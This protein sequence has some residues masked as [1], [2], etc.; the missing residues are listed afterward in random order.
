MTAAGEG[1]SDSDGSVLRFAENYGV[2][3]NGPGNN[4]YVGRVYDAV[5]IVVLCEMVYNQVILKNGGIVMQPI[6]M[7]INALA[8]P[9]EMVKKM[10]ADRVMVKEVGDGI[11]LTPIRNHPRK[12]RGMLKGSGFSTEKFLEQKQA[13]KGFEA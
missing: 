11:L 9:R 4:T 5:F 12:L 1:E 3:T 8:L 2:V 6:I 7:D 10:G 13:D